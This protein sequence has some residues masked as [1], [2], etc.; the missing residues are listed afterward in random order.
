MSSLIA[1]ADFSSFWGVFLSVLA[2]MPPAFSPQVPPVPVPPLT[3][4]QPGERVPGAMPQVSTPQENGGARTDDM[5]QM[6]LAEIDRR[7]N[8][9]RPIPT[10]S[11]NFCIHFQHQPAGHGRRSDDGK[12]CNYSGCKRVHQDAEGEDR[13]KCEHIKTYMN[14]IHMRNRLV[15]DKESK[16]KGGKPRT[17]ARSKSNARGEERQG[18]DPL[19]AADAWRRYTEEHSK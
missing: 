11:Q 10:M 2:L 17:F 13:V 1:F 5:P 7:L 3:Q 8:S 12:G 14:L 16:G 19:Q 18:T 9:L 4:Q 15:G 6:D